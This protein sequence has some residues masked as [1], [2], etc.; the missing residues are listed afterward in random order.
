MVRKIGEAAWRSAKLDIRPGVD[1]SLHNAGCSDRAGVAPGRTGRGEKA[2]RD[3]VL[4]PDGSQ[5]EMDTRFLHAALAGRGVGHHRRS[6]DRDHFHDTA[7]SK[8]G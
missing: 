6:I 1:A 4:S 2:R 5:C 3:L 7:V 8:G